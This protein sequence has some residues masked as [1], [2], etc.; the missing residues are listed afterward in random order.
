MQ[1]AGITRFLRFFVPHAALSTLLLPTIIC[2]ADGRN[3]VYV[4]N[5]DPPSVSSVDWK[6]QK[7]VGSIPLNRDPNYGL[8]GPANRF[9][10]VVHNVGPLLPEKP[11]EMAIVDLERRELIRNIPLWLECAPTVAYD[12]PTL[13]DLLQPWPVGQGGERGS[14]R[15]GDDC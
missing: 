12:R 5:T 6:E 13:S 14:A 4:I 7:V 3:E 1:R 2:A 10:Y 9:L 8:M 11:S 15:T